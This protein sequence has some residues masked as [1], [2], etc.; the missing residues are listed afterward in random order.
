MGRVA[1]LGLLRFF[2]M[3]FGVGD[4]IDGIGYSGHSAGP[5]VRKPVCFAVVVAVDF[6]LMIVAGV[7]EAITGESYPKESYRWWTR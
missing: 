2:S 5:H 7:C 4:E 1:D 3:L 6:F